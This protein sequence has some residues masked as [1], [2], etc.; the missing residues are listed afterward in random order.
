MT[1]CADKYSVRDYV[2]SKG[3]SHIL[4]KLFAVYDNVNEIDLSTLPE[5]FVIKTT[6]GSGTNIFVKISRNFHLKGPDSKWRDG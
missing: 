6:N 5:K 2:K 1:K 3:L 4:T